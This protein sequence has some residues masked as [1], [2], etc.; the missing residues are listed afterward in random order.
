ML[1]MCINT[2]Q[3][4]YYNVILRR[5][6]LTIVAEDKASFIKF[7]KCV[8]LALVIQY[9]MCMHG[10]TLSFVA[11]PAVQYFSTLSHKGHDFRGE[12]CF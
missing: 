5:V 8:L 2:R 11:C 10:I 9:A 7:Y 3:V 1:M 6:R 4:M 12:K